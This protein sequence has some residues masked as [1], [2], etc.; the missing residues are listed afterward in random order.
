MSGGGSIIGKASP[1]GKHALKLRVEPFRVLSSF[2]DQ[3]TDDARV[4][5]LADVETAVS[6]TRDDAPTTPSASQD[7]SSASASASNPLK[8]QRTLMDMFA[9]PKDARSEKTGQ[10]EAKKAKL[11]ALNSSSGGAAKIKIAGSAGLQR[12][13]FI[14][15][16]LKEFTESI[17]ENQ[18]DLLRLECE[19]MGK[20]W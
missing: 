5:Y 13:N 7:N 10:P 9:A 11:D 4:V 1:G 12:L 6:S 2:V 19:C 3:M 16:S 17:P 8:R 18:R 20:S 14:P 15:F